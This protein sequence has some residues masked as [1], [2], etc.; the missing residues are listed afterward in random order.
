MRVGMFVQSRF[1]DGVQPMWYHA[2]CSLGSHVG[3]KLMSLDNLIGLDSLRF[4]DQQKIRSRFQKELDALLASGAVINQEGYQIEYAK[5]GG[6]KC[7]A[8]E[9]KIGKGEVRM[10]FLVDGLYGPQPGWH[11]VD[12]Y[13][14]HRPENCVAVENFNGYRLLAE[15]DLEMVRQKLESVNKHAD[16]SAKPAAVHTVTADDLHAH[17]VG[18]Q[19]QKLLKQ[20]N[21]ELWKCK[22]Q[23]KEMNLR[24]NELKQ[25]LHDNGITADHLRPAELLDAL[26]D[27]AYFGLAPKCTECNQS[28]FIWDQR[29]QK[30]TCPTM[31]EWGH[32]A[33]VFDDFETAEFEEA[34]E[35]PGLDQVKPH[36]RVIDKSRAHA[37]PTKLIKIESVRSV[38]DDKE[39]TLER[40]QFKGHGS[41]DADSGLTENHHIYEAKTEG[42]SS[43]VYSATLAA[44]DIEAGKNSFYNIQLL[45]GDWVN[46][47]KNKPKN[48][49]GSASYYVFRKWGRVG[50]SI[51]D[52]RLERCDSLEEAIDTFT[53]H[54]RHKTGNEFGENFVKKSRMFYPVELARPDNSLVRQQQEL[55]SKVAPG[56]KTS[57]APSVQELLSMMFDMDA[58][59]RALVEMEV[60]ITKMP[61]GQISKNQI[62]H[63]YTVLGEILEI[64]QSSSNNGTKA[65]SKTVSLTNKFYT[66]IPHNFGMSSPPLLN[67]ETMVKEKLQ[68]LETML[69]V[70]IATDLIKHEFDNKE[71]WDA[72]PLDIHYRSLKSHIAP[73]DL[74]SDE[75]KLIQQYVESTHAPTHTEYH[76]EIQQIFKVERL[77]EIDRYKEYLD[78]HPAALT[79][80]KMLWHGSRLTNF[81][82][83]LSQGLRIAPP[84][85]PSTGYMFGK[86]IYFADMV[87]K[88]ANYC[89]TSPE[90]DIGLLVL[91]EVAL[92]RPY[93][94]H[95][96]EFIQKLP[97]GYE[98]TVGLGETIPSTCAQFPYSPIGLPEVVTVNDPPAS[99][100][101]RTTRKS[102]NQETAL[103]GQV[104]C[105]MGPPKKKKVSK[106]SDLLYNEYIVYDERQVLVRYL[107]KARFVY[108]NN[109]TTRR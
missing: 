26:A 49:K 16:K 83:I 54:F 1:H 22:D 28:R 5:S 90:D 72:D 52:S 73:L 82:G 44:T 4:D 84:E 106:E 105:P 24:S 104:E 103:S 68:M 95:S 62:R 65:H 79:N 102:A 41:V 13:V 21:E 23:I 34:M 31:T 109:R 89:C 69:E 92:G 33:G 64:L 39:N 108:R 46:T 87:T 98:S 3:R 94:L 37:E 48:G 59:K 11:H 35:I 9:E 43:L 25:I 76:L 30:Y 97:S 60:D 55:A 58:M 15:D 10:G 53:D 47:M 42:N 14:E 71:D 36:S 78:Q 74:D 32:C 40:R 57:L 61:L 50:T 17:K 75:F 27:V 80:R 63:A 29:K 101:R 45:E 18:R 56:S 93:E 2:D 8:C 12:C 6:S 70:E 81:I 77:S 86:G 99:K 51:G 100:K 19:E 88:S 7:R 66:F 20:Q 107:I 67:S 85:A 38:T 91:S 96:S